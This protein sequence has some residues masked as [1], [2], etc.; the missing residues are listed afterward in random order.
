MRL[1]PPRSHKSTNKTKIDTTA[2]D[3]IH[4]S[5]LFI[6]TVNMRVTFT[7]TEKMRSHKI[8]KLYFNVSLLI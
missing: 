8:S 7:K 4:E 6:F 2:A 3:S 5:A 1:R